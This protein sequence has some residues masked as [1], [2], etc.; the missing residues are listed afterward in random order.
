LRC[1][2]MGS[3]Y[4]GFFE[5]T[6]GSLEPGKYADMVV[7]NHDLYAMKLDQLRELQPV[8]TIV[9][10]AILYESEK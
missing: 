3:A 1:H 9:N 5:A 10:G 8:K 2:T 6:T 7:W 4:A